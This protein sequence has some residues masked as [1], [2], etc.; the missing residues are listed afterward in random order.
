MLKDPSEMKTENNMLDFGN[1]DKNLSA[2][3][4]SG[5]EN[6]RRGRFCVK[7]TL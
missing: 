1:C 5:G 7:T 4:V 3:Y 2:E 6:G